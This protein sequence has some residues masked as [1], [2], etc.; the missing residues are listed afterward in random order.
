MDEN[1][2][3]NADHVILPQT[4]SAMYLMHKYWGRKP[5]NIVRSYINKYTKAGDVVLDPFVG[6]GVTAFEALRLKRHA[7]AFDLNPFSEF[8]IKTTLTPVPPSKLNDAANQIKESISSLYKFCYFIDCSECKEEAEITH[9]IFKEEKRKDNQKGQ[10]APYKLPLLTGVYLSCDKC[11]TLKFNSGENEAVFEAVLAQ[12]SLIE[13]KFEDLI[14]KNELSIPSFEFRY[15]TGKKYTQLR[16]S[17]IHKPQ[18][19]LLFTKRALLMLSAIQKAINSFKEDS[20]LWNAL[21]LSFS[22]A[23]GQ[24]SKMVWVISKRQGKKLD[25]KQIGSWTHHFFW[26][27]TEYFEVNAWNC[28]LNR[29][30][31]TSRGYDEVRENIPY[32]IK[33]ARHPEEV[34]R[35]K[36][37]ALF[38]DPHSSTNLPL[39]DNSVDFIFTDPPYGNSIQYMELSSLWNAWLGLSSDKGALAKYAQENEIIMNRRQNKDR[40]TYQSLLTRAFQECYRVLKPNRWLLVTFHNTKLKIRN[41][42]VQ[43]VITAGFQLEQ[44]LF[45]MPPRASLKSMLHHSGSPIGDYYIRFKKTTKSLEI[46][47]VEH[48]RDAV[49]DLL[50]STV[51]EILKARAEP[52]PWL[53]LSNLLD[54]Q[55]AKHSLFPIQD[56]ASIVQELEQDPFFTIDDASYWWFTHEDRIEFSESPLTERV[57]ESVQKLIKKYPTNADQTLKQY[58][59]NQVYSKF[60]GMLTPDKFLISKMIQSEKKA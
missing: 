32:N 34:F 16:H 40:E 43:S 35:S 9:C 55:L 12:I 51:I 54:E 25:Y 60:R 30:H 22:A 46:P 19:E 37:P 41:S 33:F 7:V 48:S 52:T 39:K 56:Y 42:L 45:Q 58:V 50:R 14:Q 44:M 28:F 38:V 29:I 10:V 18:L 8:L 53:W 1:R 20:A 11:G 24:A 3:P 59:F 26:N 31:K 4:H 5:A 47:S 57:Q 2:L 36:V 21:R 15:P 6:S 49:V 13:G 23:L 27:P 17:L